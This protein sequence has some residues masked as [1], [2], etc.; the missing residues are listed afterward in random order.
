MRI[1]LAAYDKGPNEIFSGPV[2]EAA[3]AADH[4]MVLAP[5]ITPWTNAAFLTTQTFFFRLKVAFLYLSCDDR[6]IAYWAFAAY[7]HA[8]AFNYHSG[9]Q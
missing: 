8:K 3:E 4:E 6:G 5:A 7:H 1:G 2:K 9:I